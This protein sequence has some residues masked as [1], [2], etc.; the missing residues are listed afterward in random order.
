MQ[1]KSI[2]LPQ[3]LATTVHSEQWKILILSMGQ[4]SEKLSAN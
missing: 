3:A 4:F 2:N 1:Y